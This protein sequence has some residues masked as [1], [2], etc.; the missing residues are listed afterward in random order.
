MKVRIAGTNCYLPSVFNLYLHGFLLFLRARICRPSTVPLV[1]ERLRRHWFYVLQRAF[2][3]VMHAAL[4]A[5]H[6][7][8]TP[9]G[10]LGR[11]RGHGALC[12][13]PRLYR[14][15]ARVAHPGASQGVLYSASSCPVFPFFQPYRALLTVATEDVFFR[16][17]TE[18]AVCL[19]V[20]VC[21]CVHAMQCKRPGVVQWS[22][23][24]TREPI[25]EV[26]SLLSS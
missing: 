5:V 12:T 4:T 25:A 18:V 8:T 21:V 24:Y 14:W 7:Y 13:R 2:S 6:A 9:C 1:P 10:A 11:V 3:A 22:E 17:N 19:S 23:T 26:R 20:C 16:L 15:G